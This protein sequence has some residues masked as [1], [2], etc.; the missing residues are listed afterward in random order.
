MP[1]EAMEDGVAMAE[2]T[3]NHLDEIM[4]LL[5][6]GVTPA[7]K[8]EKAADEAKNAQVNLHTTNTVICFETNRRP[9]IGFVDPTQP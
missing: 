9:R 7:E 1:R 5:D 4:M 6:E 8:A 2:A 3:A